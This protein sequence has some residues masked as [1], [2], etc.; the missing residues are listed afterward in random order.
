MRCVQMIRGTACGALATAMVVVRLSTAAALE[1]G[2][3]GPVQVFFVRHAEKA[4]DSRDPELSAAGYARAAALAQMFS[5]AKVTHLYATEY[6][7][8]QATL[9]VLAQASG[10]PII[11]VPA[12]APEQQCAA[13]RR[14]PPGSLAIVA[15]H[16]NTIPLLVQ[17]LGGHVEDLEET[18]KGAVLR[19]NEYDRMFL[20]TL[21]GA[22]DSLAASSCVELR[23][24]AGR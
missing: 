20:L 4:D 12:A 23:Y 9:E 21:S 19:E 1:A 2:V 22:A 6:K 24:G 3:A 15:G 5:R 18:P 14:L 16:S 11:R 7:R 13:L 10:V 8:T 17:R